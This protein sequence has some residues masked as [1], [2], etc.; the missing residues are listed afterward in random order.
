MT[1]DPLGSEQGTTRV[2]ASKR[3][4]LCVKRHSPMANHNVL[5]HIWPLGMGGPDTKSNLIPLCPTTHSEVH[6]ILASF[7]KANKELPRRTGQGEYA[8]KLAVQGWWKSR[9]DAS[10]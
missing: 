10:T 1:F 5:H 3:P 6:F 8:Y 2:L 4:C 9:R 7:V